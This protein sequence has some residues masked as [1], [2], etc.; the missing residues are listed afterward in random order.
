MS[1][2]SHNQATLLAGIEELCARVSLCS[3]DAGPLRTLMASVASGVQFRITH[4]TLEARQ[5]E[6]L[7]QEYK[8]FD[9]PAGLVEFMQWEIPYWSCSRMSY[10]PVD[11][12]S[13]L[14]FVSDQEHLRQWRMWR[15]L[16]RP[17]RVAVWDRFLG[18]GEGEKRERRP[19][20]GEVQS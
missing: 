1:V 5:R 18:K 3:D 11:Y 10:S 7:A 9:D 6:R 15:R 8:H 4:P 2:T 17:V 12:D 16:P 19:V 13:V 20:G 14:G